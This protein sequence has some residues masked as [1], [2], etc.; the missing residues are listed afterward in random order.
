MHESYIERCFGIYI[1]ITL[2][3]SIFGLGLVTTLLLGIYYLFKVI[4]GIRKF[5][6]AQIQM[7]EFECRVRIGSI[8]RRLGIK[9]DRVL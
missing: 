2:R 6:L 5:A 3:H 1:V 4:N 9:P 7:G 8:R